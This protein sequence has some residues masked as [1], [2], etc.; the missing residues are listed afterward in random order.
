MRKIKSLVCLFLAFSFCVT[1]FSQTGRIPVRAENGMVATSHYLAS[2]VGKDILAKGGNAIDASV[3]TAF[4]LA[5]TLPSAGNI[6]GGGFLVYYGGDGY[7]TAFN[8]R[9]KAPMAA[10]RNMFLGPDGKVKDNSNHEGLLSVGVPGTVAGLYKA[11]QKMGSL[12]WEDLLQPAVELAENGFEPSYRMH[13]FLNWVKEHKD[14]DLYAATAKAFLK[15][16][17]D[18]YKRGEIL[19]QPDLAESLKRIQ[20]NGADGFYKGKTAKL[21]VD[22]MKENGGLITEEDLAKYEAEEVKPLKGTYRGH[23]IITMPPPSSGGVAVIEMLNILESFDLEKQGANSAASLHLLTEAMRRAFADRAMYLGDPNFNP[24]MP[25]EKLTSKEYA[26]DLAGSIQL[27]TASVSDSAN[28]NEAHLQY[29][30]PQTTHISV[31]DKDRNSVSLTYTLEHSYGSKI[32]VE[33]AGF[34]LNNEMGDFN[35]IPGYTDTNGLIG[36]KPNLVA[37]EKR[38]LSSMSPTIVA[39]DGKPLLVIGSPGGRAIINIV[40]QVIVNTLDH[41][42][43]IAEAIESPRIHHQWLPD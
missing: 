26:K 32:V 27:K 28:F 1:S 29:E 34:L 24:E 41:K 38:M 20:E 40:L 43:N 19:K 7:K 11:H 23:D 2:E 12:A 15:N 8:F 6:G 21:I 39:K 3:A 10:T 5:V 13:G 31:V 18:I 37:P 4:A 22:F 25:L 33:G 16:G 9:E 42:M 36:T 35:P 30:S 14:E 17:E